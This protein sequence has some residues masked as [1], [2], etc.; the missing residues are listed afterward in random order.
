MT[1]LKWG[2]QHSSTK[3]CFFAN[4]FKINIPDWD[5]KVIECAI[6]FYS[7]RV[8]QGCSQWVGGGGVRFEKMLIPSLQNWKLYICLNYTKQQGTQQ[9][10]YFTSMWIIAFKFH[11]T[12][13]KTQKVQSS[14]RPSLLLLPVTYDCASLPGTIP[15]TKPNSQMQW[16]HSNTE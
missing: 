12:V 6:F 5:C 14:R 3:F 11:Y 13:N 15:P 2:K 8:S 10:S 7:V 1:E 4:L 9:L 16:E